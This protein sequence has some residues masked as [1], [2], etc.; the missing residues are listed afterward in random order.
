MIGKRIPRIDGPAKATGSAKYTTDIYFPDMLVAKMLRSPLPHAKI[1]NIDISKAKRVPGVKAIITGKDAWDI[2]HGFVETPRYPADQY[3][4]ANDRV[5]YI[6]EEVACVAAVDEDTALEAIDAIHVDYEELPAV[7][8][9]F[10]AIKP[11]APDIHEF[12]LPDL[13]EPYKNVGGR[14]ANSYGDVEQAFKEAYLIREDRFESQLRTHC[15]LEPQA[16]V[17]YYD[18]NGKLNVWTSSMGV[19]R[20]RMHL[21]KTLSLPSNRIR[22]H[23]TYV[24]GAFGGKID[25]FSHEFCTS[26]ISIK[27]G[28]P[29]K[30][31]AE[32]DEI[33]SYFRHGQPMVIDLKTAVA[34]DGT[35]LGQKVR[36]Y[37]S[38][39]AYRGSGVVCIF[40]CWGFLIIPYRIPNLDY[41]GYSI[42]TNNPVRA[43]QRGHGAPQ[44][45]F[46]VESQM[47]IIAEELGMD[48]IE[49]R[50]KNA[51]RKGEILPNGDTVKNA[52]LIECIEEAVKK[53]D[54]K[55]KW[56]KNIEDRKNDNKKRIRRG[57]GLGISG[58]FTGTLIYPNNSAAIIK[59]NDDGTVKC[60]TGALD[61]GQGA[62]TII[63]QIIA[64]EL[65]LDVGD[66]ELISGDTDTTPVDIGSWISGLTYVTG[67]AVKKAAIDAKNQLLTSAAKILDVDKSHLEIKDK[68]IFIKEN[69]DKSVTF[70]QAIAR[71]I[72]DYKGDPIIGKGFF[73]GLKDAEHGPSLKNAKGAWS[74]SYAFDAQIAEVEVDM[75]TGKIRVIKAL[76]AHD[77]GFPIN[78]LLVECQIDGQVSMAAGQALSEEVI[79]KN[80]ITLNP[81]FLE[82]KLPLA[83]EMIENDYIDIITEEYKKDHHFI[84][85]EVGEGYVSAILAAIANAVY[86]ASGFRAKKLPITLK[87]DLKF[88]TT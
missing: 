72:R 3:C 80:G 17:A 53:I 19:F 9:I 68:K 41:I 58:Y 78:P 25:L 4:L 59:F 82:Y 74:D 77:C 38:C 2:K 62:E 32:R 29:V 47:D 88:L 52:G 18:I 69:P 34:K 64:E 8:D 83:V 76:T 55:N 75:L 54:F 63:T 65:S 11:D 42:Y 86:N 70:A 30:Y 73:R 31:V 56:A 81:S 12:R 16:T 36:C 26:L 20:K 22:I 7:F 21:S 10:E 48:P 1:L 37:N 60:H 57:I 46:A 44:M 71:H 84:T 67:N 15:Y 50:L 33:F 79:M 23:K 5:R 39:G 6:G 66:I 24:G 40:L 13:T 87:P 14:C 61:I 27:T 28:K 51:R 43:P 45:R 49:I 35:I 85:K